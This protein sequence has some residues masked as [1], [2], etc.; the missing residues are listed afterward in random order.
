VS[1]GVST[2][3]PAAGV[4][5][6]AGDN[7]P[8][9]ER[10]RPEA[11]TLH[12]VVRENLRTLYAAA[13]E[14]FA[15]A[16]LP[17]FVRAELEGYL[18][19]G[20]LQR[21]F[22]LVACRDCPER[23]LVAFSCK[24]RSLC[25]SCLGRRMAQTTANLLDHVVPRCALRQFVL[26]VPHALRA[27]LAFDGPLLG[28]VGRIFVD[29]VLGWYRRRMQIEGAE[30]GRS[31]AVTVVQRTSADLKLHP[32]FHAVLLDGV[33]VM[34]KDG[35]PVFRGL[36]RISDTAVADL[37]LIIRARLIRFLVRRRVVE[38]D[39]EASVLPGELADR[40]PALARLAAAA[41][42]GLPPAGPELRRKPLFITLP[43]GP[44][45]KVV[46]PLCI[47]DAGFSLHAATRA[48]ALDDQG[49]ANLFRYVLR[50]PIAQEHVTLTD[51]G[52]V[53]LQLKKAFRDGTFAVEMDPL[54]LLARLAASVH[55]PR[56]HAVRYA[57]VLA[58]HSKLR[59]LV[60]PAPLPA[61]PGGEPSHTPPPAP[62]KPPTHRCRYRPW[63]ELMKRAF[64]I[65]V[66]TCARC[67]G[68]MKLL[69]LVRDPRG[70]ARYLA[71]L[72]E[73]TEVPP[74]APARA[75]PYWQSTILRRRYRE[76]TAAA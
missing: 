59:P 35:K 6:A 26:T 64:A 70:I 43:A 40:D 39:D 69:A 34:G 15:G 52:L 49:R 67:G 45:P 46:R 24:S 2:S 60:V 18:D 8:G 23:R 58:P 11:G 30:G 61:P 13:E 73:S 32:H 68:R 75:P 16:P 21:G 3:S 55:P 20:L 27:R 12:R 47:E 37:L 41:V 66:E 17:A 31:G 25:P 65:D 72:G 33:F 19:C 44:G 5:W 14:G 28:A 22:A 51:Q 63:A 1:D 7:P 62:A 57:G 29:T 74:L 9:Y 56:F 38:A 50:P 4:P 76:P 53:R 10:R 36:P 54:S 42:Q 48:G 71:H